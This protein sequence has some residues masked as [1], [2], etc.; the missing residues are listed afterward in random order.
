[1]SYCSLLL[2]SPTFLAGRE[3]SILGKDDWYICSLVTVVEAFE[4]ALEPTINDL[5][6]ILNVQ[7]DMSIFKE[8]TQKLPPFDD[9]LTYLYDNK[10][11]TAIGKSWCSTAPF[12][13]LNNELFSP[14]LETN[15]DITSMFVDKLT[16][17]TM[18]AWLTLKGH[19][20]AKCKY[21][22]SLD[23]I[24]SWNNVREKEHE[25][26]F[27]KNKWSCQK[28]VLFV[29]L[30]NFNSLLSLFLYEDNFWTVWMKI[31]NI[32]YL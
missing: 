30:K 24:F 29:H 16:K 23:T 27:G 22:P 6:L 1:M 14:K 32:I 18:T 12:F 21:F 15:Q 9:H 11:I 3:L 13:E 26:C 20:K 4:R 10:K 2:L 25:T 5:S 17:V 7:C 31:E 28:I 19:M 8:L